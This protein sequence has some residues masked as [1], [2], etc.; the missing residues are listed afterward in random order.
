MVKYLHGKHYYISMDTYQEAL[1]VMEFKSKLEAL[2]D[3]FWTLRYE[4]NKWNLFSDAKCGDF[5]GPKYSA[6]QKVKRFYYKIK[7]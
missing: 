5:R 3:E 4:D 7:A 1:L 6:W 2:K